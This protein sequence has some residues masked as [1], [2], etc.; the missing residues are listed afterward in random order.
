MLVWSVILVVLLGVEVNAV[1]RQDLTI[2]WSVFEKPIE[3]TPANA[4]VSDVT[5]YAVVA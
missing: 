3:V 4:V 1:C 5:D 2:L